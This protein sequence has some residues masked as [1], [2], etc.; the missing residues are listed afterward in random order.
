MSLK[1]RKSFDFYLREVENLRARVSSRAIRNTVRLV[2]GEGDGADCL[3]DVSLLV[4]CV[5]SKRKGPAD[6]SVLLEL[7]SVSHVSLN[8]WGNI[9]P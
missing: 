8:S 4:V 6:V 2:H 9:E 5:S 1:F 3:T 7:R